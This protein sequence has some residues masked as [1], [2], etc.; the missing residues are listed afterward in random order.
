MI[1]ELQVTNYRSYKETSSFSFK[2]LDNDVNEGSYTTITLENGKSIRLL[3]SAVILG[4]NASGKSNIIRAFHDIAYLV[5]NSRTFDVNKGIPDY[6][7]SPFALDED[8][9][10]KPVCIVVDFVVGGKYYSYEIQ[11]NKMMFV[12]EELIDKTDTDKVVFGR[13]FN[14]QNNSF[15]ITIGEGWSSSALDMSDVKLLPNQLLLSWIG[16]REANGLQFV[17]AVFRDMLTQIVSYELNFK[18]NN[19]SIAE[20]VL[21]NEQGTIFKKI[22]KLMKIADGNIEDVRMIRNEDSAF[23]FP[24][25]IPE[26]IKQAFINDNRWQFLFVHHGE[27]NRNTAFPIELESTGTKNLFGVAALVLFVLENGGFLVYDEMNVAMHPLLFR[28][29]VGLFHDHETNPNHAQLI[30]STHDVS[31]IGDSL[32]RADQIWFAEKKGN[33]ESDLYSVQDFDDV[34]IILPFEKW[35][36]SG[37]FGAVPRFSDVKKLF[38]E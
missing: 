31:I 9:V 17:Y 29:L 30:F 28:L 38:S 25:N 5:S 7:Y 34:S 27:K 24:P 18:A 6:I 1:V 20:N 16:T 22:K 10:N 14:T 11:Y 3:H 32:M 13:N 19:N 33:G 8:S 36:R 21:K 35:Y 2:A 26:Q 37:R 12:K 15:K 23:S 4:A